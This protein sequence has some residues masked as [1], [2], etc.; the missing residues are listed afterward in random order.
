MQIVQIMLVWI[1]TPPRLQV[2]TAS[3]YIIYI[4]HSAAHHNRSNSKLIYSS[5][6]LIYISPCRFIECQL[7]GVVNRHNVVVFWRSINLLI[8]RGCVDVTE[9]LNQSSENSC[10]IAFPK[11]KQWSTHL[12]PS[13]CA[14]KLFAFL[15][16]S[17]EKYCPFVS[18][19]HRGPRPLCLFRVDL[20]VLIFVKTV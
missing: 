5:C 12:I 15:Y 14:L 18:A 19:V 13:S 9:F 2:T 11:R 6:T 8:W 1:Y 3:I 7:L 16:I 4:Q 20:S 10:E 17:D